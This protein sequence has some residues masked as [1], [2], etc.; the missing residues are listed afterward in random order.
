MT[1]GISYSY[2]SILGEPCRHHSND[3]EYQVKPASCIYTKRRKDIR[4]WVDK[5]EFCNNESKPV[6]ELKDVCPAKMALSVHSYIKPCNTGTDIIRYGWTRNVKIQHRS[7]KHKK[8][9]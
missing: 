4:V 7:G 1:K 6:S 9:A 2:C 8:H 5:G 3:Q